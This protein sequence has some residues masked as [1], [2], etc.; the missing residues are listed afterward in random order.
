MWVKRKVMASLCAYPTSLRIC[1]TSR[2][3]QR[4]VRVTMRFSRK[5][6][7]DLKRAETPLRAPLILLRSLRLSHYQVCRIQAMTVPGRMT[8]YDG[9]VWDNE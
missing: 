2:R 9:R 1:R 8:I 3:L 6:Y 4:L 5:N 7:T